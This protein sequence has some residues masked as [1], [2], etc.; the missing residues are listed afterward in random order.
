MKTLYTLLILLIA[1]HLNAQIIYVNNPDTT[2]ITSPNPGSFYDIDIDQNTSPD[3]NVKMMGDL[4]AG[5]GLF[6]N[7]S[8]SSLNGGL[9]QLPLGNCR[10]LSFGDSIG[11]NTITWKNFS[12]DLPLILYAGGTSVSS[13]WVV[14]VTDGYF[15]F[16]FEISGNLHYGW[17]RIDIPANAVEMTIKDWAYNSTPNQ[18]ITAGQTILT[19]VMV[20]ELDK[21]FKV[22][23]SDNVL[24]IT[25]N[26][27]N[28]FHI[29]NISGQKVKSNFL[30]KGSNRIDVSQLPSGI[31]VVSIIGSNESHH[32]KI[33]IK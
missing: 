33:I 21:N 19:D 9:E 20:N 24:N 12:T 22:Y 14:P 28:T 10:N 18:Q 17:M 7:G 32:E 5:Y 15:G 25:A 1:G 26:D 11:N 30:V 31:Y 27:F 4:T 16:K 23:Q 29:T 2:L 13:E 3:F 6:T 8:F